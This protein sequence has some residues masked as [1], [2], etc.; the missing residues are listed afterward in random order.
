[1][2]SFLCNIEL[3][4]VLGYYFWRRMGDVVS[5]LFVMGYYE[6]VDEFFVEIFE[7]IIDLWKVCVV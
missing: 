3:I 2:L 6:R 4:L 7:F 1:M 5:L